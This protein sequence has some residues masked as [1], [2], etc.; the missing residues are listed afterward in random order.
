MKITAWIP[1]EEFLTRKYPE[2]TESLIMDIL[3]KEINKI[4]PKQIV[5]P[6]MSSFIEKLRPESSYMFFS[7]EINF[8]TQHEWAF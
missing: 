6:D 7:L 8:P 5:I 2:E 1:D 4:Y 3:R